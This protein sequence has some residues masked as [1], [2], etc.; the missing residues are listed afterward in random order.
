MKVCSLI[1]LV[2]LE[3]TEQLMLKDM[4]TGGFYIV[5]LD[6]APSHKLPHNSDALQVLRIQFSTRPHK[7]GLVEQNSFS[8]A[9]NALQ[10]VCYGA[11]FR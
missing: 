7:R 1:K 4:D 10:S 9:S 6:S 2:L 8:F 11:R 3:T 5:D